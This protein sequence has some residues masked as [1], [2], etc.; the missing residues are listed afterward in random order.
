M[1]GVL[2]PTALGMALRYVFGGARIAAVRPYLKAA[3]GIV[4]L[5]LIYSN[6]SLSLP[7]VVSRPDGD[8]LALIA[9]AVAAICVAAFASG[10]WLARRLKLSDRQATSL[11]FGLG[12][13]NNGTGLVLA[14]MALSEH[15]GAMLP[16]ICY[17]LVQHVV[18]GVADFLLSRQRLK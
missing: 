5:L 11:L 6:A 15:P 17:N 16:I 3:N 13:N 14:G 12:L 18:A 4:L 8:Y 7:D 2:L 10:W 9:V 1:L